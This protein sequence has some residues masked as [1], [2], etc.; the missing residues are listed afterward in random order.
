MSRK[1]RQVGEGGLRWRI[2]DEVSLEAYAGYGF[3]RF[4][5]EGDDYDDRGDHH[6]DREH[7]GDQGEE[8]QEHQKTCLAAGPVLV[9][10][11][12]HLGG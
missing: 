2:T 12:I 6:I 5:F 10:E 7:N 3:D 8:E 1:A 4:F 11:E 9:R